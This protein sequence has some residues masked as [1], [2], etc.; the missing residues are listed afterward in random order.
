[1]RAR[2]HGGW[3]IAGVAALALSASVPARLGAQDCTGSQQPGSFSTPNPQT[4]TFPAPT[5]ADYTAGYI[6]YATPVN[7][8]WNFSS[9]QKSR[10][11]DF[12]IY[13]TTATMG[14]SKPIA[15]L[16]WKLSTSST[17]TPMTNSVAFVY[18]YP[19]SGQSS[20]TLTYN[21]R[22]RLRW[23]VDQAGSYTANI[24]YYQTTK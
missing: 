19:G 12:C 23:T 21:F 24:T 14:G 22:L 17:W 1:M 5:M 6:S 13:S 9:A 18:N 15:D 11:A 3:L 8:T 20:L 2:R 16:E 10:A 7:V 4:L